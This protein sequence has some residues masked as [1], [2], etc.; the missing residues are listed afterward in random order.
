MRD[1]TLFLQLSIQLSTSFLLGT[2][3]GIFSEKVGQLNLGI[4]GM[5]IVGSFFG[6]RTSL[7]TSNPVLSLLMAA[8]SGMIIALIYG[9]ITITLKGNQTVTGFAIAIFGTGFANFIGQPF[10]GVSTDSEVNSALGT[11]AIPGLS[12]IPIV[13]TVLFTQS[14][15][16][17]ISLAAAIVMWVYFTKTRYGLAARMVGENPGAADASGIHIDLYKYIHVMISGALCGLGGAYLT[18]VFVPHWQDN[19]TDGIGWIA[20]ALVIFS[21]WNPIRAIFSCY[22]FGILK[23][24]AVRFQGVK[25]SFLGLKFTV[26]SQVMDILPYILTI[27]V[28]ILTAVITKNGTASPAWDGRTYFR[29]ERS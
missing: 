18:L 13:G 16:V 5:M 1:L 3:G 8:F 22:L 10:S 17:Y 24:L 23:A 6:F 29:E 12:K 21:A 7:V 19:I 26:A 2:L 11:Y 27:V 28:L 25:I 9:L 15:F 14:I 4:E 20:V